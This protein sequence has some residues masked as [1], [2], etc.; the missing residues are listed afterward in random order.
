MHIVGMSSKHREALRK[1]RSELLRC[2]YMSEQLLS[3]L[4]SDSI[5]TAVMK[6]EIDVRAFT[7]CSYLLTALEA[8][9]W[10]NLSEKTV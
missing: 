8:I 3:E 9:L 2:I 5:I 6:E 7:V 1:V 10:K 4:L